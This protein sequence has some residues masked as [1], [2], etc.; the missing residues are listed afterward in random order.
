MGQRTRPARGRLARPGCLSFVVSALY[1][2]CCVVITS[3]FQRRLS[4][5]GAGQAPKNAEFI[6]DKGL[7]PNKMYPAHAVCR[8][9]RNT[10]CAG[11]KPKREVIWREFLGVTGHGA[12]GSVPS[13][14][15]R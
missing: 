1:G 11:C 15:K 10:E 4:T 8:R 7:A 13:H 14:H 6:L 2:E 12:S 9:N 3:A 5:N